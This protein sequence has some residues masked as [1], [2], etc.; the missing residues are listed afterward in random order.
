M[1]ENSSAE[2]AAVVQEI[3]AAFP[4]GRGSLIPILQEIQRRQGYISPEA[5]KALERLTGISAT[6]AYG[7]ATFYT[8]FRFT[9]P[10]RHKIQVC[11]GTACHVRGGAQVLEEL[12]RRLGISV[13]QT[14]PDGQFSLERVACLGCCALSPVVAVDGK[15]YAGMTPKKVPG[16]LREYAAQATQ[17][18]RQEK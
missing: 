15:V 9:R 3:V 13:G 10:G 4:S 6:E 12:E 2:G 17:S 18:A 16:V 11:N 1:S 14:T 8:Q 5:L 7:V